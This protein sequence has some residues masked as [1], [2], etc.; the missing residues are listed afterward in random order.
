[1]SGT[2]TKGIKFHLSGVLTGFA[3]LTPTAITKAKPAVVAVADV[4]TIKAGDIINLAAGATGFPELDG[5]AWIVGAVNIPAKTFEILGSDT[6]GSTGVLAATPVINHS[7]DSGLMSITCALGEFTINTETPGNI[8]TGTYCD[9]SAQIPSTVVAAGTATFS[10]HVDI[11]STGYQNLLVAVKDGK[12]RMLRVT[13]PD[14]G[15]LVAPLIV[16]SLGWQVPLD[17]VQG[18]S[19]TMTLTSKFEHVF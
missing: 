4:S 8:S 19:G 12:T 11:T 15:Y 10:G 2:S 1:M 14:N 17:G 6:T 3:S 9:P 5:K 13:L 18:F 16:S 7:P